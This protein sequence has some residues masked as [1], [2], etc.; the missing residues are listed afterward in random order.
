[1]CLNPWSLVW[2]DPWSLDS[3][4]A[5]A[6]MEI[7][8]MTQRLGAPCS[9]T[10]IKAQTDKTALMYTLIVHTLKSSWKA[11]EVARHRHSNSSIKQWMK[12]Q[13]GSLSLGLRIDAQY[14]HLCYMSE[15]LEKTLEIP[16]LHFALRDEESVFFFLVVHDQRTAEVACGQT[17]LLYGLDNWWMF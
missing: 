2:A 11:S 1:M 4:L 3:L 6:W 8:T 14:I 12:N 5:L 9:G 10:K 7:K 13:V 15:I 17:W 16:S